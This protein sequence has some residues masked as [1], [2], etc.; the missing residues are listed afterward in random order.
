MK[1]SKFFPIVMTVV[2]ACGTDGSF[3]GGN[4]SPTQSASARKKNRSTEKSV[5]ESDAF[6]T[7]SADPSVITKEGTID[8]AQNTE[9]WSDEVDSKVE[10]KPSTPSTPAP[11][12]VA[13]AG[14]MDSSV[15]ASLDAAMAAKPNALSPADSAQLQAVLAAVGKNAALGA[16]AAANAAAIKAV[17]DLVGKLANVSLP[18][19]PALPAAVNAA[20]L[21]NVAQGVQDLAAA[22]AA[23]NVANVQ[24]ALAKIIQA[25]MDLIA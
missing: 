1:L 19:L 22:A 18:A 23:A 11:E 9:E 17:L 3:E 24:A 14:Q 16:G 20:A 10:N 21:A 4:Q 12:G 13:L 6:Q 15:K 8:T 2:T 25:I 7:E 5:V